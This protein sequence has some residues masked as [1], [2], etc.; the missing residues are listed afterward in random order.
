MRS[1]SVGHPSS[2]GS[3]RATNCESSGSVQTRVGAAAGVPAAGVPAAGVSPAGVPPAGVP[4]AGAPPAGVPPAGVPAAGVSPAGVPPAG[5]P[6]A[7]VSPAGVPGVTTTTGTA[8]VVPGSIRALQV[9]HP[10]PTA[11]AHTNRTNNPAPHSHRRRGSG[12]ASDS[13][14]GTISKSSGLATLH[15]F[16]TFLSNAGA[17]QPAAAPTKAPKSPAVPP[18]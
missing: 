4:A 12:E 1:G 6:P 17:T 9:S 3:N 8:V 10:T 18:A 11:N 7:G 15:S 13:P 5:V 2:P 14:C 16:L